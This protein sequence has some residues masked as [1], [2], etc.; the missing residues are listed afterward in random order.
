[1]TPLKGQV[2][3][4]TGASG[5]IGKAICK[6]LAAGGADIAAHYSKDRAGVESAASLVKA[7]GG[8][9]EIIRADLSLRSETKNLIDETM[10]RLGRCDILVNNAGTFP[11]SWALDLTEEEWDRVIDTNL[12]GTFFCSQAAAR[13][14]KEAGQGRIVNMASVAIR[15]IQRGAHYS[16]SKAGIIGLTRTL[17]LEWAPEVLVNCVAPGLIDTPQPRMGMN[18]GEIAE[19]AQR[20]PLARIGKPEDVAEAVLFLVSKGSSWVTG[21]TLHVNGG[22]MMV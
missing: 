1:M 13:V 7:A 6:A 11:R 10:K 8:R 22:D 9:V 15:G 5:G 17:A 4:V 20:L 14:M 21:Q 19:R 2:A 3:V 18:E 12:K 16:A